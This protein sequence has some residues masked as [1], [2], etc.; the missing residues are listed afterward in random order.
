MSNY[1]FKYHQPVT[2]LLLPAFLQN[3]EIDTEM[4]NAQFSEQQWELLAEGF[5]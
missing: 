2:F 1:S 4:W 3:R 5:S